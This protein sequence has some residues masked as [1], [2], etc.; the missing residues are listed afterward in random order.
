MKFEDYEELRKQT[1]K[2]CIITSEQFEVAAM[3]L[4]IMIELKKTN[5]RLEY[6]GNQLYAGRRS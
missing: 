4:D 1:M 3:L 6:I 5:D 2:D